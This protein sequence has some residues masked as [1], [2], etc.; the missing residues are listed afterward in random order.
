MTTA[1]IDPFTVTTEHPVLI[2]YTETHLVWIT[3]DTA[4]EAARIAEKDIADLFDPDAAPVDRS[5]GS[6]LL[7][8]DL[9]YWLD[10]DEAITE[11]LDAYFADHEGRR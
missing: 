5:T 4:E 1:T 6:V 11:R 7:D 9:A 8:E 2:E 10:T 3:A